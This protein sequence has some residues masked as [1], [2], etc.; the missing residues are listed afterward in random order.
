MAFIWFPRFDCESGYMNWVHGWSP[1]KKIWCCQTTNRGCPPTTMTLTQTASG[2]HAWQPGSIQDNHFDFDLPWLQTHLHPRERE[3]AV[4]EIEL[5][6]HRRPVAQVTC[7]ERIHFASVHT[8]LG[9]LLKTAAFLHC[10]R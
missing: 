1:G 3:G 4:W 9:P 8:F 5:Q 10:L 6:L 2:A 7:E